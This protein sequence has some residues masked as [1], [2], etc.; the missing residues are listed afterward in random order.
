[1]NGNWQSATGRQQAHHSRPLFFSASSTFVLA[2]NRKKLVLL[3]TATSRGEQAGKEQG[4][5]VPGLLNVDTEL[6]RQVPA[7]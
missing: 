5:L 4:G 1:M 3:Q 2:A 6:A 7:K